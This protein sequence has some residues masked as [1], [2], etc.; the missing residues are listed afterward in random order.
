MRMAREEEISMERLELSQDKVPPAV[1]EA[2]ANFHRELVETVATTAARE[3]VVGG[4]GAEPGGEA[5][6]QTAATSRCGS[7]RWH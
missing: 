3:K 7:R 1:W 5:G 6:A 4:D 2:V